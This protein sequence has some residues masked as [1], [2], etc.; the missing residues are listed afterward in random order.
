MKKINSFTQLK[1]W[2]EAHRLTI[3]TY[4]LTRS[5]PKE[6]QF[7]LT[8]QIRRCAVSIPSNIAE[9]FSRYSKKEKVNFYRIAK[10][11]LSELQS[12]ILIARDLEYINQ[13]TFPTRVLSLENC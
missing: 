8:N 12:Q 1:V 13:T 5:F 9:G 10:G 11:S 2:K 7:G 6:E 3:S 4:K